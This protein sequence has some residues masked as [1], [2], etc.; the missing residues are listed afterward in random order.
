MISPIIITE[1]NQY[2]VINKPPGMATEPPSHMPTLKDWLVKNQHIDPKDWSKEDRYGIVH[3]LDTDT[4]GVVIWAKNK[5][6]Q[7][8]LRELWRGRAVEKSY[9]ALTYGNISKTGSIEYPIMRNNKKDI[10][11]AAIFPNPKARTAITKYE[12]LNTTTL[13]GAIINLVRAHPVTGRTHQIRVHLKSIGNPIVG[14]KLY[15]DK[16]AKKIASHLKLDRQ[17]LHA[18][19]IKFEGKEYSASLPNDLVDSL[20][21]LK[22][23][24]VQETGKK[25]KQ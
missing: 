12:R 7:D 22:I 8:H 18:E 1:N 16:G 19:S 4:S 14:D 24:N 25:V 21:R 23:K 6:S 13:N 9:I 2:F 10:Q 3:R 11:A 5:E 15:T 17:F 20:N